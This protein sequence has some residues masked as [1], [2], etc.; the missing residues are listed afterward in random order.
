VYLSIFAEAAF[1]S[2][3]L[4]D[5]LSG[6][7]MHHFYPIY[8]EPISLFSYGDAEF[9][10]VDFVHYLLACYVSIILDCFVMMMALFAL[11]HLG[12]ESGTG[13]KSDLICI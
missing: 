1:L 13:P 2:H 12:F 4:L 7:D 11:N 3:L 6:Y 10:S 5:D 9:V 8:K